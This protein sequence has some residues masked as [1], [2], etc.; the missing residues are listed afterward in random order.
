MAA[1]F[2]GHK[3][4]PAVLETRTG[5]FN[6]SKRIMGQIEDDRKISELI[7]LRRAAAARLAGLD[8][9][10]ALAVGD[11]DAARRAVN[12]MNAQTEARY[13]ARFAACKEGVR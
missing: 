4:S 12:E 5:Q 6:E 13:A 3:K 9:E 11:R 8:A 7:D 10:I 1:P 2:F